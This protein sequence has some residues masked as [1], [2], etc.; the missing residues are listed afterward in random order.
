MRY[1][2]I[3]RIT[4]QL[5]QAVSFLRLR[6]FESDFNVN[7]PLYCHSVIKVS[8]TAVTFSDILNMKELDE[9]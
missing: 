7:S 3:L 5:L 1:F 9:R 4:R 8:M 6:C 2:G